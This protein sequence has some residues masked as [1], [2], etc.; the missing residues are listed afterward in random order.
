MKRYAFIDVQNTASTAQKMLGFIIDWVKLSDYLKNNRSCSEV[1]LYSGI[2]TGDLETAKEFDV[3]SKTSCCVLKT[4]SIFAYKNRDKRII[5]KCAKCNNE[6]IQTIDMGYTKKSNCDV[7]LS[8]DIIER[9]SPDTEILLFT[10]DG[11]FEYL[12]RRVLE[13]GTK[14]VYIF[15]YAERYVKFGITMSRFSTKLRDLISEKSDS[16]FYVSLKDIREKIRKDMTI[17]EDKQ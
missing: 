12:I 8:V 5:L 17:T 11:D 10:G 1:Y 3:L 16:V 13:K 14:K 4:K 15:S 2:D 6:V 7:E 9:A